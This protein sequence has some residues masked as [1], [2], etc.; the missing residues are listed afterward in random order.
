VI[1][2]FIAKMVSEKVYVGGLPDGASVEEVSDAFRKYG[3]LRKVWIARRP[4]GF[5]F[6]EFY[7][8]RDAEDAV[9]SLDGSKLC[10]CRVRVEFSTRE[11]RQ[12]GPGRR[13]SGNHRRENFGRRLPYEDSR[14]NFKRSSSPR[15]KRSFSRSRSPTD[16]GASKSPYNSRSRSR[17]ISNSRS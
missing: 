11:Q 17:S 4:P 8:I 16:R 6:I 9:R 10:G 5:G 3:R 12:R 15:R 14:S 2:K 13:E 7:D 1:I